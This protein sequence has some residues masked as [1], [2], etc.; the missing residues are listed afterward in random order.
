MG[1]PS[2]ITERCSKETKSQLDLGNGGYIRRSIRNIFLGS[3]PVLIFGV[4]AMPVLVSNW[5]KPGTEEFKWLN[6]PLVAIFFTAY[7]SFPFIVVGGTIF[8][9]RKRFPPWSY[10][11][12][13]VF[14]S[15]GLR[16]AVIL[17][18]TP[19]ILSAGLTLNEFSKTPIYLYFYIILSLFPLIAGSL[20]LLFKRGWLAAAYTAWLGT[21]PYLLVTL[22]DEVI[23]PQGRLVSVGLLIA[24]EISIIFLILARPFLGVYGFTLLVICTYGMYC[25]GYHVYRPGDELAL[26]VLIMMGITLVLVLA[27][28]AT[29]LT[30]RKGRAG[31]LRLS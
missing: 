12:L 2:C 10:S 7:L 29:T 3:V 5:I 11:W 19:I 27:A 9:W 25:F 16:K 31:N 24:W 1:I 28:A 14:L 22:F 6:Y 20:V 17:L 21:L 26:F 30:A 23:L 15:V 13:G 18:G 4:I 8:A